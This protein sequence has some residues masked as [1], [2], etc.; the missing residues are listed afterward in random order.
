MTHHQE[1]RLKHSGHTIG[2]M[3]HLVMKLCWNGPGGACVQK[4]FTED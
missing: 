2:T 4:E 1:V 3:T